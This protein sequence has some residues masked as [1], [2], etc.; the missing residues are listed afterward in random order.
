VHWAP[1][2]DDARAHHRRASARASNA[3]T[4]TKGKS[5]VAEEIALNEASR[6]DWASR[7]S[8][9]TSANTSSSFAARAAEPH[10]RAGGALTKEQVAD[11]FLEH[12][13]ALRLR[14]APDRACSDLVAEA[15]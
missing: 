2:A 3:R 15:R 1:T 6:G 14:P 9:P 8:R 13:R 7:R 12:H 5:M 4:I 10:H 11:T